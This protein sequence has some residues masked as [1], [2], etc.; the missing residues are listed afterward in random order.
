MPI[1]LWC[2]LAAAILPA[3][4]GFPAKTR[5]GFDNARPRDLDFWRDGFAA[6]ARGAM[7]NGYEAFPLFAV[8]VLVGLWQGGS[9][10]MVDGLAAGYI[11]ARIGFVLAYWRDRPTL[12]SILWTI[13]FACAVAIFLTPI[14]APAAAS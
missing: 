3:L 10:G 11:A 9:P 1:A 5:G 14:W 4:S 8:A 7:E 13:A 2:V 6:R 12:R